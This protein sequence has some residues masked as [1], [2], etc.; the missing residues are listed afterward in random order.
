MLS[1]ARTLVYIHWETSISTSLAHGTLP[2]L[3]TNPPHFP[4]SLTIKLLK[5]ALLYCILLNSKTSKYPD[6]E[7]LFMT[8][9]YFYVYDE[10]FPLGAVKVMAPPWK[11]SV[12]VFLW[13][14]A[15][16]L[17]RLGLGGAAS[18]QVPASC[19]RNRDYRRWS[20]RPVG[21]AVRSFHQRQPRLHPSLE[22][23]D[24]CEVSHFLHL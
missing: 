3:I 18:V 14:G 19:P 9:Y 2:Q 6:N 24:F 23:G 11:M 7:Q 21:Q 22:L 13:N 1:S 5:I 16:A 8:N 17:G 15:G 20:L 10:P 12:R 4:S